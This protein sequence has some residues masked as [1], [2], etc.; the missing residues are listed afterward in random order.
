MTSQ[1]ALR[2]NIQSAKE[3][4][5][6]RMS[7]ITVVFYRDIV[8]VDVVQYEYVAALFRD[9][10]GEPGLYFTSERN[11]TPIPA[12]LQSLGVETD[13]EAAG[14][15]FFCVFDVDGHSNYGASD[16]WADAAK[17]QRKVLADMTEGLSPAS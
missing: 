14:S 15:H 16:D 11:I 8:S 1:L 2:P 5:R 9:G 6:H 13:G 17:F 3:Y 12:L 4:S 10:D 7:N